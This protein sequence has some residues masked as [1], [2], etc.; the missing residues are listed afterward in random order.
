MVEDDKLVVRFGVKNT[1]GPGYLDYCFV[2]YNAETNKGWIEPN[3]ARAAG[4]GAITYVEYTV[5]PDEVGSHS[6]IVYLNFY[7]FATGKWIDTPFTIPNYRIYASTGSGYKNIKGNAL[8]AYVT[9]VPSSISSVKTDAG[10]YV[11][12]EKGAVVIKTDADKRVGVYHISGQKMAE[13]R[14]T[15]GQEQTVAL[16]PGLYIV[17]GIKMMVR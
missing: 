15:A 11:R 9:G 14:L 4:N 10:T 6:I 2:P 16:R 8:I 3:R 5:T 17:D 13:V 7:D 12:G 1:G